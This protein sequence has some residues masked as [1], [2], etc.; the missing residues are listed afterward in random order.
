M[1]KGNRE[2]TAGE[3]RRVKK[4]VTL[5]C[6][7]YDA[8]YG[9][10]PRDCACYMFGVRFQSSALCRYFRESVLPDAPELQAVFQPVPL[11]TCKLCGGKFPAGSRRLYC[12]ERCAAE[13]R[14]QQTAARVRKYREKQ[15]A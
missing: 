6:A 3:L 8:E 13:A 14:K 9:C 1:T 2:L 12:S 5:R 15:G 11:K 4:L 7:N 10:L